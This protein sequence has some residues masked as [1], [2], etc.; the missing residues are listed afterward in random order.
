MTVF[1]VI[2]AATILILWLCIV[3]NFLLILRGSKLS[4]DYIAAI[5]LAR[6]AEQNFLDAAESYH[7]MCRELAEKQEDS[8]EEI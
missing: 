4:K 7:T 1:K 5:N 2:Y 6:A 8:N 3:I